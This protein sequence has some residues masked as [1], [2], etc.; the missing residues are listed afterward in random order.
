MVLSLRLTG[1]FLQQNS[2]AYRYVAWLKCEN[3]V[4]LLHENSL[5]WRL[6]ATYE[7]QGDWMALA[8][9][10]GDLLAATVQSFQV[11]GAGTDCGNVT[12]LQHRDHLLEFMRKA[13]KIMRSLDLDAKIPRRRCLLPGSAKSRRFSVLQRH[14]KA[15]SIEPAV[16]ASQGDQ[17]MLSYSIRAKQA[18]CRKVSW[19]QADLP[20]KMVTSAGKETG[21]KSH[22]KRI[23][24]QQ[25][26]VMHERR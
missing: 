23:N 26:E 18:I 1:K 6:L 2:R 10:Q 16:L 15:N 11:N 17:S 7:E 21:V 8:I 14:G 4:W 3:S 9:T 24:D 13:F 22:R 5:R 25:S 12:V 20:S 19:P